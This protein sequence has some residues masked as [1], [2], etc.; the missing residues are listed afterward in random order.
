MVATRYVIQR[1]LTAFRDGTEPPAD[2][3]IG[4]D[5]VAVI[6]AAYHSAATGSRATIDDALLLSLRD[7]HLG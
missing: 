2:G 1:T 7:V 5:I 3:R 6:A 4:R